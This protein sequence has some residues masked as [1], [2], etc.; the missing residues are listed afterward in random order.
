M[1][2]LDQNE[3]QEKMDSIDASWIQKGKF[4]CREFSFKDFN[5]AFAFMTSVALLAEKSNHHPDWSN[6]YNT[7]KVAL[8]THDAD[9]L[10]EKDF[11]LAS[12]IDQLLLE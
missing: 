11:K 6:L 3:I 1:R 12:A 2:K 7:V 9:G 5:S 4:I 8:T 10:T